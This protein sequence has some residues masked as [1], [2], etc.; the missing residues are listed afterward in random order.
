M[1]AFMEII[2]AWSCLS[3]IV[4]NAFAIAIVLIN[5]YSF[6][7]FMQLYTIVNKVKGSFNSHALQILLCT[8][9]SAN[10]FSVI[11]I[12]RIETR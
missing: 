7:N 2:Q 9:N 3:T 6:I 11:E 10:K 4:W 1:Q 8:Q 5:I 12:L